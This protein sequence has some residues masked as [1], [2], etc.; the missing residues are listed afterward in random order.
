MKPRSEILI[1]ILV[2]FVAGAVASAQATPV[3]SFEQKVFSFDT[4]GFRDGPVKAV[5][6]GTN[7]SSKPVS[8]LEVRTYCRCL[9]VKYGNDPVLP[10]KKASVEVE[11]A[12]DRLNA[13]QEHR[14]TV[15]ASD[16][17]EVMTNSLK[18]VGYV[19]RD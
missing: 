12:I 9:Q 18:L 17:G 1:S 5:F 16:G 19:K 4:L 15:L 7:V 8:I 6:E 10:G 11:L 3:L 2:W 14:L 13:W